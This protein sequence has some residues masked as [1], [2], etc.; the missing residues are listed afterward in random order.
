V[1]LDP[2][3]AQAYLGQVLA[4]DRLLEGGAANLK[5]TLPKLHAA[6]DR[7]LT[8]D[9]TY[10]EAYGY[11]S[12]ASRV[13]DWKFDKADQ[14]SARSMELD[15]NNPIVL[16][17]RGIHLLAAGRVEEALALHARAVDIDPVDLG[18]R[19]QLSRAFYLT[20]RYDDAIRTGRAVLDFDAT[21]SAPHEWIGL[22]LAALGRL[23]ESIA[24]LKQAVAL[25]PGNAERQAALAY[26]YAVAAARPTRAS[27]SPSSRRRGQV[28]AARTTSQP[29]TPDSAIVRPRCAG[30]IAPGRHA[31]ATSQTV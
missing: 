10:G 19:S 21:Q 4:W 13:Y 24:S 12:L 17:W 26:A 9:P 11:R 22:S 5:E 15:P 27:S 20:K 25:S 28:S 6:L 7:A 18:V 23:D 14:D 8:I 3:Y 30:S 1:R 16:Q 31:T 2:E 29:S